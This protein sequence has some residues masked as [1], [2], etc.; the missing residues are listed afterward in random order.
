MLLQAELKV[1]TRDMLQLNSLETFSAKVL[2]GDFN[3]TIKLNVYFL[4][5]FGIKLFYNSNV[6]MFY[7]REPKD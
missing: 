1:N 4:Q 3:A 7:T 2:M 6:L 5:F